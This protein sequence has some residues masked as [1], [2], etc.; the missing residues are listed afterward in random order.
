MHGG[1]GRGRGTH[2]GL[3][4][5]SREE[6][7]AGT[8]GRRIQLCS[9]TVPVSSQAAFKKGREG[10]RSNPLLLEH[11]GCQFHK[12]RS[13]SREANELTVAPAE[14]AGEAGGTPGPRGRPP[15][16][17]QGPSFSI[18]ELCSKALPAPAGGRSAWDK[19]IQVGLSAHLPGLSTRTWRDKHLN[20]PQ[21][22]EQ[23]NESQ[24]RWRPCSQS[25]PQG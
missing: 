9:I 6:T 12:K 2:S 4:R 25:I 20:I 3:L 17:D 7:E 24:V 19:T 13:S 5:Q 15:G 22:N 16:R 1:K 10:R 11:C 8:A 14:G 21:M 18:W 23:R